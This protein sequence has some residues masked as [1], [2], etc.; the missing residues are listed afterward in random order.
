[1]KGGKRPFL[2][3]NDRHRFIALACDLQTRLHGMSKNRREVGQVEELGFPMP[4]GARSSAARLAPYV[5]RGR[6]DEAVA[7]NQPMVEEREGLVGG[8]R[9]QPQR[10]TGNLHGCW[11]E[12]DAEETSQRDFADECL[13][14]RLR[15]LCAGGYEKRPATHRR[16]EN[17]KGQDLFGGPVDK[18]RLQ[19][20]TNEI[21]RQ[22]SRGVKRAGR[23]AEVARA[24]Q[25]TSVGLVIEHLF[26]NRAKLLDVEV[27]IGNAAAAR[28][29]RWRRRADRKQCL[30]HHLILNWLAF[31]SAGAGR[32]EKTSVECCDL[33]LAGAAS[34]VRKPGD[35][36]DRRPDPAVAASGEKY[37]NDR[38]DCVAISI[39]RMPDWY[40]PAR[41]REEEK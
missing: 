14:N 16:V 30:R 31:E 18:K 13:L 33:Q 15:E 17:S 8:Q 20:V 9:G 27:L 3:A 22:R 5:H 41:F 35:G 24:G 36:V 25:L 32:R 26:V 38:I 21:G 11:I 37:G 23:L 39:N 40:E 10:E 7:R 12:V 19:G 34:R 4:L 2:C 29:S 28:A 1:M 6:A